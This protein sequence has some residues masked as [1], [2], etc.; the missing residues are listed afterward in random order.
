MSATEKVNIL[1]VDDRPDK[2]K[3][4]GVALSDLN[5][6]IVTASSGL[7]A[8]RLLL[9]QDFAVIL[10]VVS[11]PDIDGFETAKLIRQRKRSEHTPIIFVTSINTTETHVTRGYSLGAVDY[12]FSPVESEVLRTKVA[13]FIDLF[14]KTEQVRAQSELLRVAAEEKAALLESHLHGLLNRLNVGIF[15]ASI[16]RVIREANPAFMRLIGITNENDL[17]TFNLKELLQSNNPFEGTS[18]DP[19]SGYDVQFTRSDGSSVWILLTLARVD[20]GGQVMLDGL[21]EDITERKETEA[22]LRTLNDTLE[23]RVAERTEALR[24]SQE[25]LLRSER[26]A[27]LGTLA[28]GIAHEINNPLNAILMTAKYAQRKRTAADLDRVL[29]V[30]CDEAVRGGKIVKGILKFAKQEEFTKT[31]VDVNEVVLHTRD[32]AKTYFKSGQVNIELQLASPSPLPRIL[33]NSTGIEQVLVNLMSNAVEAANGQAAISI[34]TLANNEHV[35]IQVSDNGPGMSE[36]I[37]RQVF[38]P[39]FSTKRQRG[40]TGLGL[41]ICHGIVTEHGGS[42]SASSAPGFGTTFT[43]E[44]PSLRVKE[45]AA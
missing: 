45:L 20:Y 40:G 22:R 21:V 34:K 42:I 5:E 12:I 36:D 43:I 1:L 19:S 39:F 24:V 2:L 28:A 14:R 18:E 44:I 11:M 32:L 41:S 9:K 25:N 30:I 17:S 7:E 4:L 6:N 8:L 13:V 16:D 3:A 15:R 38:D 33:G 31:S 35:I 23:R 29:S 10:L 27:S 37:L 26:L